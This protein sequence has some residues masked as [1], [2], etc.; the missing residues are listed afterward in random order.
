MT[1]AA[2]FVDGEWTGSRSGETFTVDSPA[3]GETIAQVPQGDRE[4]T[5]RA[6]EV[7]NGAAESCGTGPMEAFTELQTVVLS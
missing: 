7:A 3:T 1:D 6:I 2:M 5:R 4:D